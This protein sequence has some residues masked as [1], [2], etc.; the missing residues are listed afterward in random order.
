V[1]SSSSVIPHDLAMQNPVTWTG[2]INIRT[3]QQTRDQS[4]CTKYI[5]NSV[6]EVH[7]KLVSESVILKKRVSQGHEIRSVFSK[8]L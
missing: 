5:F 3:S 6:P 7:N 8:I 4:L 1:Q 2:I